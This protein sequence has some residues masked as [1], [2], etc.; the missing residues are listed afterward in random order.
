[1]PLAYKTLVIHVYAFER[2]KQV[3]KRQ[4]K[5]QRILDDRNNNI[6]FCLK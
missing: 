4:V 1:M 3:Q 6:L 2:T 5:K